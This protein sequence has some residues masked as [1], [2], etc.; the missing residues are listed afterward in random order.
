MV[1]TKAIVTSLSTRD[2]PDTAFIFVMRKLS[3]DRMQPEL[4]PTRYEPLKGRLEFRLK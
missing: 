1:R 4:P 3:S 2:R